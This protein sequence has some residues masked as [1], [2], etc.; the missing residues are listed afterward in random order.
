ML[1]TIFGSSTKPQVQL[2]GV[3][4]KNGHKENCK[5]PICKNMMFDKKKGGFTDTTTSSQ[6]AGKRKGNGHKANCK[7]PICKNMKKRRG[8][9]D[10]EEGITESES[11]IYLEKALPCNV[12]NFFLSAP[13]R[14]PFCSLR[15]DFNAKYALRS[16]SF[17]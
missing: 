16:V 2:G 6:S 14:R 7:C 11:F 9:G 10:I 4:K 8:G 17:R 12:S 15:F 13:K 1:T 5:C 3:R